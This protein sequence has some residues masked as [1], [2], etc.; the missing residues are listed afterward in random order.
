[1]CSVVALPVTVQQPAFALHLREKKGTGFRPV[2]AAR[3]AT[4]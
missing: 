1:V 2:I 3:S 4:D